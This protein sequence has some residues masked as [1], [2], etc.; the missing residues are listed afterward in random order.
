[1]EQKVTITITLNRDEVEELTGLS[2]PL[3]EW[4]KFWRCFKDYY[5]LEYKE[6][7]RWMSE[8]WD[9]LKEDY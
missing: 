3:N 4:D 2:V 1:M 6:T 7:L 8:E 9:E 5:Q